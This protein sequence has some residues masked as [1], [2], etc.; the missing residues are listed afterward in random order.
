MLTALVLIGAFLFI[1]YRTPL[2]INVN[3]NPQPS[4]TPQ[5]NV[6]VVS[7]LSYSD[8]LQTYEHVATSAIQSSE[9]ALDVTKWLIGAFL[10]LSTLAAGAAAYLYKTAK[11]AGD[12][13]QRAEAAAQDA[14]TAALKT[15][16]RIN[17]LSTQYAQL[18]EKYIEIS[19]QYL[20]HRGTSS[21]LD[22]DLQSWEDGEITREKIIETQQWHSWHKWVNGKKTTGWTELFEIARF[23]DGLVPI[24]KAAIQVELENVKRK[25]ISKTTPSDD[26]NEYKKRLC[27]L[28][29]IDPDLQ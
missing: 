10:A 20:E 21:S 16:N 25:L 3:A 13:A 24:V 23:G 18:V 6:T 29:N 11:E 14:R 17:E 1:Q 7:T 28:L 27:N 2:N 12:K 15:E 26:E 9:R 8:A 5:Q 22:R 4:Q 19:K